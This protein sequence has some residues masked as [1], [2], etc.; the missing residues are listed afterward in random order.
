[1]FVNMGKN[2]TEPSD[3]SNSACVIGNKYGLGKIACCRQ[4]KLHPDQ[5]KTKQSETEMLS[6]AIWP[7][8]K[9][10]LRCTPCQFWLAVDPLPGRRFRAYQLYKQ[11]KPR[12][13]T[14]SSYL[15]FLGCSFS[16]SFS[17]LM[18]LLKQLRLNELCPIFS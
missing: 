6:I 10:L 9:L 8:G 2:V 14:I 12:L 15:P 16:S 13:K 7:R 3:S 18:A 1:M 5:Q 4:S 17:K 11:A